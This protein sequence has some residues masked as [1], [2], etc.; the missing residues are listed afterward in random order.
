[1]A[2]WKAAHVAYAM[3]PISTLAVIRGCTSPSV[4]PQ[5]RGVN[6]RPSLRRSFLGRAGRRHRHSSTTVIQ[7]PYVSSL[8]TLT[9][10]GQ[11]GHD[12]AG[13]T[14]LGVQVGEPGTGVKSRR[15]DRPPVRPNIGPWSPVATAGTPGRAAL[16]PTLR[17]KREQ[18]GRVGGT[19][20]GSAGYG[21]VADIT[22]VPVGMELGRPAAVL[23]TSVSGHPKVP[24]PVEQAGVLIGS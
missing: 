16:V 19:A 2:F 6:S 7:A 23:E 14:P 20:A 11:E 21:C 13:W 17:E 5:G 3:K 4:L 12:G 9:R 22:I 18:L 1:M 24:P 10:P 8:P 15:S